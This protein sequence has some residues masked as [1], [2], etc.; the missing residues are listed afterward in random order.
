MFTLD[1]CN[2][3]SPI[4]EADGTGSLASSPHFLFLLKATWGL[5]V[6]QVSAGA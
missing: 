5:S 4:S 1:V 2:P 3:G 6:V